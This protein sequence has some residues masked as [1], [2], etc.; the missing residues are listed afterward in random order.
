MKQ[1]SVEMLKSAIVTCLGGPGGDPDHCHN[2]A[3]ATIAVVLM[4]EGF[5][6]DDDTLESLRKG[7]VYEHDFLTEAE[8]E[9]KNLTKK[10]D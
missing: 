8:D 6:V 2:E 7:N 4:S 3:A 1:S 10:E 5:E 9:L